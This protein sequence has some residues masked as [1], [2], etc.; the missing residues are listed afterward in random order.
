[1]LHMFRSRGAE[2]PATI[3]PNDSRRVPDASETPAAPD[4]TGYR[5]PR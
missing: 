2:D 3:G 1:M 5:S 4:A